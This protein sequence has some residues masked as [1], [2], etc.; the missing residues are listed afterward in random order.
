MSGLILKGVRSQKH[1]LVEVYLSC[2]QR[3]TGCGN[4]RGNRT[5]DVSARNWPSQPDK[6]HRLAQAGLGWAGS[7]GIGAI[8]SGPV[9]VGP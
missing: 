8:Q 9:G 7:M 3:E 2:V 6:R 1:L 5:R 4:R